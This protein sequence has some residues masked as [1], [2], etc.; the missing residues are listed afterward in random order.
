MNEELLRGKVARKVTLVGFFVNA[1]LAVFKIAAGT[2]GKSGAMFADGIHSLSD[3]L[4]DLVVLVGIRFTEQPE[5][6]CHNYGHGKYETLAT[7][8]ISV[9]LFV[10][11][12]EI[13]KSGIR[14]ISLIINGGV[15]ETP[16]IIALSAAILSIVMKEILYRYTLKAGKKIE[17][18][19]VIANAWHH[20]SDSFSSIGTLFGIG[21]AIVLG[22]KWVVL[23]PIASVIVSIFIFK[24]A[25]EILK[26]AVDELL[27]ISLGDEEK[28]DIV[29]IIVK[30]K[31]VIEYHKIRTRK[32]G[33]KA[34]IEFH[35]LVDE[36]MNVK[37]AHEVSTRIEKNLKER[38]GDDSIITV[39]IEPYG[40]EESIID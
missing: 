38:F 29:K 28:S 22:E 34:I 31:D 36:N 18:S 32:I 19:S 6:D 20:R 27:E 24:V 14:N 2:I 37:I 11:G 10:V 35:I 17:S 4:T 13:L 5:D 16:K 39:H 30:E 3:F 12:F 25:F 1:F 7:L 23:D 9:F 15:I 26:P 33:N 8:I 21:G 40:I